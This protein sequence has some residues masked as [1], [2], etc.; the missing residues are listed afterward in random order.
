MFGDWWRA[1]KLEFV[2]WGVVFALTA[3]IWFGESISDAIKER[4]KKRKD[5]LL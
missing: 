3:L 2:V 5:G 1:N 4:R